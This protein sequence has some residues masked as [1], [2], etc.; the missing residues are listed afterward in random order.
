M[1]PDPASNSHCNAS[2]V[3]VSGVISRS[4]GLCRRCSGPKPWEA[5]S[6][7]GLSPRAG[8]RGA[9]RAEVSVAADAARKRRRESP[10]EVRIEGPVI[11]GEVA[12]D[13]NSR[14]P[15]PLADRLSTGS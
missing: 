4:A 9:R 5:Q 13:V 14:S 8:R 7:G 1:I 11:L 10:R 3:T 12:N 6:L 15:R 2:R